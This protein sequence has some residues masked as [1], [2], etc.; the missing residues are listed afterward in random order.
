M[1]ELTSGPA[2]FSALVIFV[3]LLLSGQGSQTKASSTEYNATYRGKASFYG[4]YWH[5]KKTANGEI[6]DQNTLTAAH[7][8]LSFGTH[9]KVKNLRNGREVI[10]RINNRGPFIKGRIIDVSKRA[11][12]ELKMTRS[13]VVPVEITVL[14]EKG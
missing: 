13:G 6:Y 14:P 4:G 1:L 10:L 11:A 12:Q 9:V 2:R 5:G 8:S 7:R 3:F